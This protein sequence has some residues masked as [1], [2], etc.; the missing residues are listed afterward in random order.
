MKKYILAILF[1]LIGLWVL[2][3]FVMPMVSKL[4][5]GPL[6]SV[7]NLVFMIILLFVVVNVLKIGKKDKG[8]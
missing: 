3:L 4:V 7:V 5:D 2:G 1:M 8:S 6:D